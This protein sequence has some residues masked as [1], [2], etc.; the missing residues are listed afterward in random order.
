M[1]SLWILPL[2]TTMLFS[3]TATLQRN[4]E[5]EFLLSP[6]EGRALEELL[7]L[8]T[9]AFPPAQTTFVF[10]PTGP[11]G[12]ALGDALRRNGYAITAKAVRHG[13]DLNYSVSFVAP[14]RLLIGVRVGKLWRAD[15]LY[16]IDDE[17]TLVGVS[18]ATIVHPPASFAALERRVRKGSQ[19]KPVGEYEP[20][21]CEQVSIQP[22]SLRLNIAR[23]LERC[24]LTL[25]HWNTAPEGF[26][27]D[28]IVQEQFDL[29][30]SNGIEGV[31]AFIEDTYQV[32]GTRRPYSTAV[33]FGFTKREGL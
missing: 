26:I 23:L 11:I 17:T 21:Q 28:W 15:R 16:A 20:T 27:D 33:D 3:C 1:K 7:G 19:L 14:E 12:R 18:P 9:P 5:S 22:G 32:V 13:Q 4:V 31:L 6:I 24:G 30:V 2:I 25:G 8:L 10:R 29:V